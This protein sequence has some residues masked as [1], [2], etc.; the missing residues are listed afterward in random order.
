MTTHKLA[1]VVILFKSLL[2]CMNPPY[3]N[4]IR[5]AFIGFILFLIITGSAMF[6]AMH[7]F[8]AGYGSPLMIRFMNPAEIIMIIISA[9][10]VK[11]YFS[12]NEIGFKAPLNRKSLLWVLPVFLI[13]AFGWGFLLLDFNNLK[14]SPDQWNSFWIFGF[15]TLLVGIAE[16]TMFRGIILHALLTKLNSRKAILFSAIAFSLLHSINIIGGVPID[17]MFLQLGLTFIAG[18][19]LT[20]AMVKI[21]SILPLIFWHW[22]WD[23]MTMGS[24]L[25]GHKSS[26]MIVSSLILVELVFGLIIW[27]GIKPSNNILGI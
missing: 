22:L 8:N 24:N 2:N 18:F 13:L 9:I 19:Y 4:K 1:G 14:I 20:A 3:N 16:E 11:R 6:I 25:I 15:V 27:F 10:I 5:A 17:G 21:K 12:W 7:F 23:F 26:I